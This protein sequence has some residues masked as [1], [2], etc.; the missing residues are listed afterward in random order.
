MS[1]YYAK[2]DFDESKYKIKL[3]RRSWVEVCLC[4]RCA[5]TFNCER[6]SSYFDEKGSEVP[7]AMCLTDSEKAP[8]NTDPKLAKL[9]VCEVK[10][11][12]SG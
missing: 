3:G 1:N 11:R 4:F 5:T 7:D 9:S 2:S 10:I 8:A 6:M 12:V